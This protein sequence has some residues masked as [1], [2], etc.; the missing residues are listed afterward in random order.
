[1]LGE[2]E[3]LLHFHT[4]QVQ[5]P[6][7]TPNSS[8]LPVTPAPGEPSTLFWPPQEPVHMW[9]TQTRLL[10]CSHTHIY[11]YEVNL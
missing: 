7:L 11:K 2:G 5:F 1:M 8:Y 6:A 4:A 3:H 9:H 10:M